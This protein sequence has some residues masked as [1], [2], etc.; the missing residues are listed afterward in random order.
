MKRSRAVK[1]LRFAVRW[2]IA[3]FGVYVIFFGLRWGD[4]EIVKGITWRDHALLLDERNRPVDVVV[5]GEDDGQYAIVDPR[6]GAVRTV[7]RDRLVSAPD[8]KRVSVRTEGGGRRDMEL[9]GLDL[10]GNVNRQPEVERLLVAGADGRGEWVSPSAVEGYRLKVP[11]PVVEVGM[12][13]MLARANPW[14]IAAALAIFPMTFVVTTLRWH[15]LM[16]AVGIHVTRTRAFVLN[17]VGAFYNT[18]MPGSTGG[19]VIKAIYASRQTPHKT[20]A[21]LCVLVDRAIGLLALI[22]MGGAVAALRWLATRQTP[23]PATIACRNVALT[24]LAVIVCML[25]GAVLFFS[26]RT[27]KRFGLD[28][29]LRRLP[30]QDLVW[31][32]METMALYRQRPGLVVWALLI[33]LPVHIT[34]VVSAM[35]CG[36]A[37]GLD[38]TPGYYFVVVPVVVLVGSVPVSPQGAGVMEFFAILLLSR[39]GATVG[40]A[41]ALTMSI[42][43][44]QVLWNLTG[45]VFVLKGGFHAPTQAERA[46][47]ERQDGGAMT[48][49]VRA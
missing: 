46:E 45:G 44:V 47:L 16:A 17:M 20:R 12:G 31:K 27:R 3:L 21:V 24:C 5:S 8:Q 32:A 2:G 18:F 37:F 34:V 23:D 15:A 9:L 38:L 41:F 13:T 22:A 4:R 6:S 33:T 48:G 10:Q 43:M 29:V 36:M 30:K 35:L 49:T 14:L 7:G 28:W 1:G 26:E 40:H 19:D 25:A 42:R 11:R 39:Q